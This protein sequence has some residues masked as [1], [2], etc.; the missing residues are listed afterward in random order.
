M[1]PTFDLN[2]RLRLAAAQQAQLDSI[3]VGI[4][5]TVY[6]QLLTSGGLLAPDTDP[7]GVESLV[8]NALAVS[9]AAGKAFRDGVVKGAG[10]Q[11]R[12]QASP[13]ILAGQGS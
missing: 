5:A 11:E 1:D 10:N 2:A 7:T 3:A 6:S 9:L 12:G 8:A 4:A 13:A